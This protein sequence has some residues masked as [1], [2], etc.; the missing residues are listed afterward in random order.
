MS[1]EQ[2]REVA[3]FLRAAGVAGALPAPLLE[4]LAE[5]SGEPATSEQ[6]YGQFLELKGVALALFDGY[7]RLSA[8]ADERWAKYMAATDADPFRATPQTVWCVN[9]GC[10][11]PYPATLPT[12]PEC[13]EVGAPVPL[14]PAA[15]APASK[16]LLWDALDGRR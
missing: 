11:A 4:A 10:H 13:G 8:M 7:C 9:P 5:G 14:A 3:A 6:T 16:D 12:C 15:V 2:V 1:P